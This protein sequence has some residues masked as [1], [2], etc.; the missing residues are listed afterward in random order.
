M[1]RMKP[2]HL[3]GIEAPQQSIFKMNLVTCDLG[4]SCKVD[5]LTKRKIIVLHSCWHTEWMMLMMKSSRVGCM[6]IKKQNVYN[7]PT[8]AQQLRERYHPQKDQTHPQQLF[9]MQLP[10]L[11]Y[12]PL[13]ID[14]LSSSSLWPKSC[15]AQTIQ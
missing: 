6:D 3:K 7:Y 5:R 2:I 8:Q 14:L 15:I 1:L 13:S 11:F 12:K 9:S 10:H 4:K